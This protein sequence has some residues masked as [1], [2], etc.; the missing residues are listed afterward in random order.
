[1][2][3]GTGL[4]TCFVLIA[5]AQAQAP[6][7]VT[8]PIDCWSIKGDP[9]RLSCF[10][11][12]PH[13]KRPTAAKAPVVDKDLARLKDAVSKKLKGPD[14]AKFEDM[15]KKTAPNTQG[16]PTAVVC[17]KVNAKNSYGGYTGAIPFVFFVGDGSAE[18]VH[19]NP[20]PGD[21]SG[22]IYQRFCG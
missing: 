4:L 12:M 19:M 10:D 13:P 11:K 7:T 2:R 15:I 20:Q 5:P 8:P 3:I 18:I 9:E 1:M 21:V 6:A 22:M 16:A 17:G 14:S